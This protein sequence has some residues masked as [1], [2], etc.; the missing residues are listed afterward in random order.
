MKFGVGGAIASSPQA[1]PGKK[2]LL[3]NPFQQQQSHK[4][5]HGKPTIHL[6]G[7]GI[8]SQRRLG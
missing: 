2:V 8:P 7:I 5:N 6:F 1:Q 3:G 4:T